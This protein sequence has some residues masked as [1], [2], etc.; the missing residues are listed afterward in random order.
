MSMR[1]P[2]QMVVANAG[3]GKTY[4]LT[5]RTIRLMLAGAE[6]R[7]IAALTFTRKAASEFLG[8]VF[9]RLA[10]AAN[11]PGEREKL[12]HDTGFENLSAEDCTQLLHKLG[13]QMGGLCMGTIDSLFG[14]IAQAFPMESGLNG[15]FSIGDENLLEAAREEALAALFRSEAKTE[16]GLATLMDLVR[17]KSRKKSE[18]EVFST[19]YAE[20]CHLQNSYLETPPGVIWG[21]R[22]SIWPNDCPIL[23]AGDPKKLAKDFWELIQK[24]HP[25][26]ETDA[27]NTWRTRL[28]EIAS[29]HPKDPLPETVQDFLEQRLLKTS[30]DKKTGEKYVPVGRAKAAR[31]YLLPEIE[32]A[33]RELAHALLRPDLEAILDRSAALHDLIGRFESHFNALTRNQ[34]ILGFQDL[35]NLLARQVDDP[36]WIASVGY[37][38]DR[39]FDHW[40]LDEFQDTSHS[41]WKVLSG[42]IDE[43]IQ[44]PEGRRTFYY[45]G[46]TKQAIFSWRGGDP[47]LFFSIQHRY[48][49]ENEGPVIREKLAVSRRSVPQ[50]LDT[51]NT[52]FGH[53]D[54]VSVP[55]ELPP[56]A[57][58]DWQNGWETHE[59]WDKNRHLPGFVQW[60]PVEK[61]AA[62]EEEEEGGEE[63]MVTANS[64]DLAV[65]EILQQVTPWNRGWECAVL[66]RS[67]KEAEAIAALLQSEGIPLTLEG[68]ANPCTDNPLGAMLLMAF[69][70]AASPADSLAEKFLGGYPAGA[71]LLQNGSF[72]FREDTLRLIASE[73]YAG[74]ARNWIALAAPEAGSFLSERAEAF[75]AAC[76]EFD[77]RRQP[78]EGLLALI[79][80]LKNY[81]VEEPDGSGAVRVMTVHKAKGLT[82]DMTIIRGLEEIYRSRG[83]DE[84]LFLHNPDKGA[85]WGVLLPKKDLCLQDSVLTEALEKNRASD[86]YANF[87]NAYVAMTRPRRALYWITKKLK[88]KTTAKNFGRWLGLRLSEDGEGFASGDKNWFAQKPV[89]QAEK[90]LAPSSSE[91][92]LPPLPLPLPH[93]AT[94]QARTPA[95]SKSGTDSP[96]VAGIS[97]KSGSAAMLLGNEIHSLLAGIDWL[98]PNAIPDFSDASQEAQEILSLFFA[99]GTGEK[100]FTQP[101]VECELWRETPFDLLL[102]GQWV[103]GI[104]DRVV[105]SRSP[106]GRAVAARVLD[107]KT[108]RVGEQELQARYS[109]QLQTYRRAAATLLGLPDENVEAELVALR[110]VE[111]EEKESES[112]G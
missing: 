85:P 33:R 79:D 54:A 68:K 9:K 84:N 102:D 15:D 82:F 100:V 105:V 97:S 45:V 108:D 52:I 50:I 24:T 80:H 61:G 4:S 109:S 106:E 42:F 53:L 28:D 49:Q 60:L 40:L 91:S 11:D 48:N 1:I 20:V 69:R 76:E 89:Q 47:E 17:K 51:V 83:G 30:E 107:F 21:D 19:L 46:D 55:L 112:N 103:S 67:N 59:V 26:L 44:D 110:P 65:L 18:R 72:Q 23:Q 14:K 92:Q 95:G 93:L 73:G 10:L 70:A 43:V 94:P 63:Q 7:S 6:P 88:P 99:S 81:G 41:Q 101:A 8:N 78:Q 98:E 3:S 12:A 39:R 74:A 87:C 35:T 22:S 34:G 29:L 37:R 64:L 57:V 75:L 31:L 5:T 56:K 71:L 66:T 111:P 16:N 58:K 38:L 36:D 32:E 13:S 86:V 104:F 77:D 25:D 2:H 96:P 90:G 62:D 27:A